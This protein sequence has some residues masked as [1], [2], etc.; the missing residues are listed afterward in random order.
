MSPIIHFGSS[1][2]ISNAYAFPTVLQLNKESKKLWIGV[3]LYWH[4]VVTKY[5]EYQLITSGSL[6]DG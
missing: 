6:V 4:D 3:A 1:V 2:L 5:H